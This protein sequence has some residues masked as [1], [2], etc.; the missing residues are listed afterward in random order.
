MS[1]EKISESIVST[2]KTLTP[3]QVINA[4]IEAIQRTLINLD[5]KK[6]RIEAETK[7]QLLSLKRKREALKREH[8]HSLKQG[9]IL[10]ESTHFPNPTE[11]EEEDLKKSQILLRESAE[12]LRR[13]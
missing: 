2:A 6:L 9:K 3:L 13:A 12:A 5:Q 4:K 11:Q 10:K 1:D 7:R 8:S